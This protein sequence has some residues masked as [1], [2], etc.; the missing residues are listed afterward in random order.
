MYK[1]T[2]GLCGTFNHNQNDDFLT[3]D[4]DVESDVLSFA[5]KWKSSS[6]CKDGR[7]EESNSDACEVNVQS[8]GPAIEHC[9]MLKGPIF[10][11]M[12]AAYY[13]ECSSLFI[14]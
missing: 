2:R 12:Y 14:F 7:S 3:P 8:K 11:S 1:Q 5:K 13:T 6:D 10:S 9:K 4:G